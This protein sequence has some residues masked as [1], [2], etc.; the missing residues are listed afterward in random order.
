MVEIEKESN[1]GNAADRKKMQA[2][3][4]TCKSKMNKLR[5]NFQKSQLLAD[6]GK[7]HRE[8]ARNQGGNEVSLTYTNIYHIEMGWK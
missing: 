4:R 1:A 5:G 7:R 6:S 8:A 2:Q 3:L